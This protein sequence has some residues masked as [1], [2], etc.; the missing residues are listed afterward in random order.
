[1]CNGCYLVIS[2]ASLCTYKMLRASL[3]LMRK[4]LKYKIFKAVSSH[5]GEF[6][7][8]TAHTHNFASLFPLTIPSFSHFCL[9]CF[10]LGFI[11]T[12]ALVCAVC[13]TFVSHFLP[14]LFTSVTMLIHSGSVHP[15]YLLPTSGF[16]PLFSSPSFTCLNQ[17]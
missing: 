2:E 15:S 9:C 6:L 4:K 8:G 14:T 7:L 17:L 5:P 11:L 13:L 12:P 10:P 16:S 3:D 1:M